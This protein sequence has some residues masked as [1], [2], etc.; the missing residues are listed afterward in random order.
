MQLDPR[1]DNVPNKGVLF[2]YP[3]SITFRKL[4]AVSNYRVSREY[5]ISVRMTQQF[6]TWSLF[7]IDR[8][9]QLDLSSTIEVNGRPRL[10]LKK[11]PPITTVFEKHSQVHESIRFFSLVPCHLLHNALYI[12]SSEILTITVSSLR[13][14]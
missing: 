7:F 1:K 11:F 4:L 12:F 10:M 13:M 6:L 5:E 14:T 8:K 9:L 3:N 2:A